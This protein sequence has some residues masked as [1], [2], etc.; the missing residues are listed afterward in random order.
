[1]KLNNKGDL[2]YKIPVPNVKQD[3]EFGL[4]F[5]RERN[6]L[7]NDTEMIVMGIFTITFGGRRYKRADTLASNEG[8]FYRGIIEK[9]PAR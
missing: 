6:V 9:H 1:M 4:R 2:K 5:N 3:I 7:S 8:P